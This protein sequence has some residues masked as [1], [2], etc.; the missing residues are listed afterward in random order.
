MQGGYTI[1]LA[2]SSGLGFSG[3]PVAG[4][5]ALKKNWGPWPHSSRL[6]RGPRAEDNGFGGPLRGAAHR[7]RGLRIPLRST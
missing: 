1:T 7:W 5:S 6:P 4:A 2:F 3:P